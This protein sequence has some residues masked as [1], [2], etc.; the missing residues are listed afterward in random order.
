[1]YDFFYLISENT[2]LSKIVMYLYQTNKY[3]FFFLLRQNSNG[4]SFIIY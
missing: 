4:Y 1:M 3:S 2:S